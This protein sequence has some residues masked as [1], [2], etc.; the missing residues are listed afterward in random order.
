MTAHVRGYRNV[1]EADHRRRARNADL[2]AAIARIELIAMMS[3][4]ANTASNFAPDSMNL[5]IASCRPGV[6]GLDDAPRM[7]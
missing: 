7:P 2:E 1:V 5:L 3:V 6:M 4:A